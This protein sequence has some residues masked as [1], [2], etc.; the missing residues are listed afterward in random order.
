MTPF[1]RQTQVVS[2][3]KPLH[4][5]YHIRDHFL[6]LTETKTNLSSQPQ[7]LWFVDNLNEQYMSNSQNSQHYK[8]EW[9]VYYL[10]EIW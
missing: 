10:D 6:Y 2:P 7:I 4:A 3:C 9:T 5:Y 8:S 1:E